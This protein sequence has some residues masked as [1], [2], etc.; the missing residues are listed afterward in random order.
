MFT[1][2]KIHSTRCAEVRKNYFE[3]RGEIQAVG[4]TLTFASAV[5]QDKNRAWRVLGGKAEQR[6][7]RGVGVTGSV[8]PWNSPLWEVGQILWQNWDASQWGQLQE[9]MGIQ[10][11]PIPA[12]AVV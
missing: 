5:P 8:Q 1:G 4:L 2:A 11:F 12:E 3:G 6:V 10:D 9:A 7:S